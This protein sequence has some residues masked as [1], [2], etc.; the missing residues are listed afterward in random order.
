MIDYLFL[1]AVGALGW[2][3]SLTTYALVAR[4][5]GWPM[6]VLHGDV[7]AIP[8]LIGILS[9]GTGLY[10]ASGRD[11]SA[12]GLQIVMFAALLA[13]FWIGFLRVGSQ[14][15]L[16]LAPLAALLLAI[17]WLRVPLGYET[18]G[19]TVAPNSV[20]SVTASQSAPR[21]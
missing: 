1:L 18:A 15:S 12:D 6:G 21:H 13:I 20:A 10:F 16:F 14:I 5:A 9:M 7:P 11:L 3:F 19:R 2:G 17:G 8:F 4:I